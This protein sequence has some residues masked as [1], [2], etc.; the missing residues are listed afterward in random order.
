MTESHLVTVSRD[1]HVKLWHVDAQE[2]TL[3][4][5]LAPLQSQLPIKVC[6]RRRVPTC[7]C[8]VAKSGSRDVLV[9]WMAYWDGRTKPRQH[10]WDLSVQS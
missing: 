9:R 3:R 1:Q 2:P 8:L 6:A 7:P 4:P 10:D 5:K